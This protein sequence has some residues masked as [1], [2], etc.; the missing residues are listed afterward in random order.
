VAHPIG[1]NINFGVSFSPN[2]KTGFG[3]SPISNEDW[4]IG[5]VQNVL[6][7]KLRLEYDDGTVFETESDEALLDSRAVFNLP[8]VYDPPTNPSPA[9]RGRRPVESIVYTSKGYDYFVDPWDPTKF[10]NK[11]D[12]F[13]MIDNPI[14]SA[15]LILPSG[16]WIKKV[17]RINSFQA[18]LVAQAPTETFFLANVPPFS[19]VFEYETDPPSFGQIAAR[20]VHSRP[21]ITSYKAYAEAGIS[22]TINAK[23]SG[24]SVRVTAHAGGR[25]PKM[26]GRTANARGNEWLKSKQLI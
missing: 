1:F 25:V 13:D 4:K 22:K 11:P 7:E 9:A 12:W 3:G 21:D 2:P 5:I 19:T 26:S 8:Y 24:R 10:D 23:G 14:L 15:K 6:F 18:W 17:S 20:L 16:G